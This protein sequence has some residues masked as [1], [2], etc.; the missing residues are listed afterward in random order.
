MYL[1][2]I[3][4][5]FLRHLGPGSSLRPQFTS[6]R[7]SRLEP[8]LVPG[9]GGWAQVFSGP[10]MQSSSTIGPGSGCGLGGMSTFIP[11]PTHGSI[12]L[13]RAWRSIIQNRNSGIVAEL[14]NPEISGFPGSSAE[15]HA[16]DPLL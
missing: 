8:P 15:Q 13:D 14:K 2:T 10:P 11:M 5:W 3:P 6:V 7:Q 4:T 1:I 9:V 16:L 12:R